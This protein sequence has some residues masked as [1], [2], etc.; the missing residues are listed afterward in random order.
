MAVKN[1]ENVVN[2]SNISVP[3]L[4]K[5]YTVQHIKSEGFFGIRQK[6]FLYLARSGQATVNKK[7][8]LIKYLTLGGNSQNNS[9]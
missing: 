9:I 5:T 6:L 7:M 4:L 8:I 1:K 3:H 2:F